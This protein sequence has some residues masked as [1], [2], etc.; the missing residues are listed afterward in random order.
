MEY[1][2]K[3]ELDSLIEEVIGVFLHEGID[4]E[5]SIRKYEN[6]ENMVE[7]VKKILFF[8]HIYYPKKVIVSSMPNRGKLLCRIKIEHYWK[9]E[10]IRKRE[11]FYELL[12]LTRIK[13]ELSEKELRLK[14]RTLRTDYFSFYIDPEKIT[15]GMGDQEYANSLATSFLIERLF[16]K[17]TI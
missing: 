5:T 10:L 7:K 1:I 9:E 14:A 2:S 4:L 16:Y 8:F 3:L 13:D 15:K 12:N 11:Y 17:R 6:D